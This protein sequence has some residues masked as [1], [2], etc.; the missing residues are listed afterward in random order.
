MKSN[1]DNVL[2]GPWGAAKGGFPIPG[3]MWKDVIGMMCVMPILVE[4][5]YTIARGNV[6]DPQALAAEIVS[7]LED[8]DE[9]ANGS[10]END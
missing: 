10:P 4:A 2:D 6:N 3:G 5:I 7:V 9:T 8:K 1:P